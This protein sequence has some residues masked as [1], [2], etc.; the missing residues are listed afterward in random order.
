MKNLLWVFVFYMKMSKQEEHI[1]DT[2]NNFIAFDKNYKEEIISNDM[3][4]PIDMSNNPENQTLENEEND[5][6]GIDEDPFDSSLFYS[7]DIVPLPEIL[8]YEFLNQNIT[9]FN[10]G[11]KNCF[12]EHYKRSPTNQIPLEEIVE[13]CVGPKGIFLVEY[14]NDIKFLMKKYLKESLFKIFLEGTCDD[15]L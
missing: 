6:I 4:D 9:S 13:D 14:Y 1:F 7:P 5:S 10:S 3:V 8:T 15:V 2:D 11:I 12:E